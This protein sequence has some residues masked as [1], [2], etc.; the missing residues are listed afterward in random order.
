VEKLQKAGVGQITIGDR[1]GMA[2]TRAAMQRST[3][4][5]GDFRYILNP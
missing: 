4:N 1:S 3:P 2:Q 5:S